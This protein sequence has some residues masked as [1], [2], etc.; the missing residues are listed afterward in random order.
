MTGWIGP[1]Q[2]VVGVLSSMG[3]KL[4]MA[5]HVKS[6]TCKTSP[7]LASPL[8]QSLFVSKHSAL[9]DNIFGFDFAEGLRD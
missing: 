4:K 9:T 5:R 2:A 6:K 8:S 3:F 7:R 1:S